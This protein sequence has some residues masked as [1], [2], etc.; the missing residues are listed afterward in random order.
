MA[1]GMAPLARR[2]GCVLVGGNVTRAARWSI[3]VTAIG[4]ADRPRGRAGARPGDAL[5]VAGELGRAALGLDLL[6][7][8]RRGPAVRAQL[9]PE[10]LVAAGLAVDG[11]ASASI[12]VSDGF[13]RDLGHLCGASGCGAEVRLEE[14]PQDRLRQ[15]LSGGEDY[16]LLL[17]ARARNAPR[18]LSTLRRTG[19]KAREVGRFVRGRGIR[20]LRNGQPRPLP[21]R[22]G[23]DH[24]A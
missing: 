4:E 5:I 16:A 9:R 12:D 13:L 23:W 21:A 18:L 2:H 20:L 3:S 11:L 6:R 8:G 10:P 24:L 17:A 7:R 1:K 19:T 22:L 15:A 14:L